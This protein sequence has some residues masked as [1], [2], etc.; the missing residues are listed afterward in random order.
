MKHA[1]SLTAALLALWLLMSGHYDALLISLGVVSTLFTVFLALRMEVVDHESYPLHL[2]AKLVRFWAW[3]GKEVILANIDVAGRILKGRKSISPR[4]FNLK[5]PQ[6][7]D[8]GRVIYANSITLTPGTVSMRMENDEIIVHAL[9]EE[10]AK[11][12]EAQHMARR[13]PEDV[14]GGEA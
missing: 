5:M 7:T 6:R 2:T 8:L 10:T 12:L 3:L 14:S 11:D 9:A 13:V 1:I 4:T